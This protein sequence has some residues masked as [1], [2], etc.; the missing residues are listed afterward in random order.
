MDAEE[1][2]AFIRASV[3]RAV[4][5]EGHIGRLV[6]TRTTDNLEPKIREPEMRHAIA[7][8]AESR[9]ENIHYGIEVPTQ[10]AYRFTLAPGVKEVSARHDVVLLSDAR[11]D[12]ARLNLVELKKDQPALS[13]TGDDID[14]PAIRKDVQ[15]LILEAAVHGKSM[16][17]ILHAA[18]AATVPSVLRKYNAAVWQGLRLS[19]PVA[20]RLGLPDPYNDDAWF[21]LFILVIRQRGREGRNRPIL[22]YQHAERF[23]SA[24]RRVAEGEP[25]F[26][27]DRLQHDVILDGEAP[28]G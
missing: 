1:F 9:G 14:C 11:H 6:L 22:Y 4:R 15:K 21:T 8:E 24:L 18:N 10:E 5:T 7:Q 13:G 3:I 26:V 25:L 17:H 27:M 28:A 20:A 12:A 19:S 2:R 23:G 16:L